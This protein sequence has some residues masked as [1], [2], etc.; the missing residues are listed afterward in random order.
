M[1]D[2]YIKNMLYRPWHSISLDDG[3]IYIKNR[4]DRDNNLLTANLDFIH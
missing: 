1:L 2:L 3:L 4:L